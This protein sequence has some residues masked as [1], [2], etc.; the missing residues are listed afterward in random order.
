[1]SKRILVVED[2]DIFGRLLQRKLE[3][4]GFEAILV[5]DGEQALKAVKKDKPDLILLDLI[6]PVRDGF[7]VLKDLH[8]DADFSKIK[9]IVLSNLGQNED[10]KRAKELGA[11][12]YLVKTDTTAQDTVTLIHK[13]LQ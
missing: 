1:M 3:K 10:I 13:H 11:I 4:E 8:E 7:Q 2:E 9:V 5:T 6:L 12:D